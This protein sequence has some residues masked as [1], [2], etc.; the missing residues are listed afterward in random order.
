MFI[1]KNLHI[2]RGSSFDIPFKDAFFDMVYTS[3]VLIHVSPG[4]IKKAISEIRRCAMRYIWGFEYYAPSYT[5]IVY[6]G[7][8]SLMWKND[9]AGL[10]V[11]TCRDLMLIREKKFKYLEN[12]NVDQMFLLE[13]NGSPSAVGPV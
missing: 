7:E 12:S 9:F 6:R 13:I 8:K 5:E 1:S 2:I 4:N 11:D 3:G 10:Y